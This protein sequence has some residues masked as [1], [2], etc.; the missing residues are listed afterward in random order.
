MGGEIFG[1]GLVVQFSKGRRVQVGHGL[2]QSET[3]W[4]CG[5]VE[6]WF[7]FSVF[8]RVFSE[9]RAFPQ[10]GCIGEVRLFL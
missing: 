8:R 5:E 6:L 2:H 7:P 4:T 10:V 1:A 3:P 9:A